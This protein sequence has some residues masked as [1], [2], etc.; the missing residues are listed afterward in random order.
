MAR[1]IPAECDLTARPV[2]EQTVFAALKKNLSDSWMVFHAFDFVARN[3]Q[4]QR[5][6]GEIDF[7]LYNPR[8]G[9]LVQEVKGG[10]I[11]YRDGVWYQRKRVIALTLYLG[12]CKVSYSSR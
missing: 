2:S 4:N 7:L 12:T 8:Y 9:M 6:E 10:A 3:G 11:A 1:M 5:W